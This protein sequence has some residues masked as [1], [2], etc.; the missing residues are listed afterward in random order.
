MQGMYSTRTK[1]LLTICLL[2]LWIAF[3]WPTRA[4]AQKQIP[5]V[6]SA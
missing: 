3:E 5:S 4:D 6:M 2:G 1:R